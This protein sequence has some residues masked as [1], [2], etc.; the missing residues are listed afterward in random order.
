MSRYQFKSN[1]DVFS[2]GHSLFHWMFRASRNWVTISAVI[3]KMSSHITHLSQDSSTSG[4]SGVKLVGDDGMLV[5]DYDLILRELFCLAAAALASRMRD[6]LANVGTLWDEIFVTGDS[7]KLG[8]TVPSCRDTDSG[9]PSDRLGHRKDRSIFHS[10]AEKGLST[11]HLQEYGRGCLMFLVRQVDGKRDVERLEAAGYRFAEIH[12][13]AGGIRSSM[14]IKSSELESRLRL[15]SLYDEGAAVPGPGVHLG[16]F[17]VRARLD[18]SGFDVLVQQ[19]ERN[20]LPTVSLPIDQLEPWQ[21]RFLREHQNKTVAA[22]SKRLGDAE[23]VSKQEKLFASELQNAISALRESLDD[24]RFDDATMLP[25]EVQVPCFTRETTPRP[26][27]C[28]LIAFRLVLPIHANVHSAQCEFTPLNFFKLRQVM[29]E[30]SPHHVEFSH[31]VH[32]DMSYATVDTGRRASTTTPRSKFVAKTSLSR[33]LGSMARLLPGRRQG[34]TKPPRLTATR[35]QEQLSKVQSHPGSL[36]NVADDRSFDYGN[37]LGSVSAPSTADEAV[38]RELHQ[39]SAKQLFGGI[40]VSQEI[41][42]DV[43]S[44]RN[45]RVSLFLCVPHSN[46]SCRCT[47]A[48]LVTRQLRFTLRPKWACCGQEPTASHN[49]TKRTLPLRPERMAIGRR[50]S[51]VIILMS[52]CL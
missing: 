17:A 46:N 1:D 41:M 20:L 48:R 22:L 33:A 44:V 28:T 19:S 36:L 43:Q 8:R 30:G 21:S 4:R 2:T 23:Y 35:S 5:K 50:R 51:A 31:M 52:C 7:S 37:K 25:R 11:A 38:E 13:V 12:Q 6:T 40:M 34:R 16:M 32:R 49:Q 18:R 24:I 45:T 10:L 3:A 15:M 47:R 9:L 14:Q 39:H 27:T 42:V 29:Y 26:S